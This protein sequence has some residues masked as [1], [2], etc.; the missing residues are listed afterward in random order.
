MA[1]PGSL[2][3]RPRLYKGSKLAKMATRRGGNPAAQT[4]RRSY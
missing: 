2:F 1:L 3:A 4:R